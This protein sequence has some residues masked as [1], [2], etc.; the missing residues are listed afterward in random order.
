MWFVFTVM[1]KSLSTSPQGLTGCIFKVMCIYTTVL[2]TVEDTKE[3][4]D[5]T[6]KDV[7]DIKA[8]LESCTY[9]NCAP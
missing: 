1:V 8:M 2:Q 7:Q 3:S 9:C 4:V 5:A 6:Q